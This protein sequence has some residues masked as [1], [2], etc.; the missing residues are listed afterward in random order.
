MKKY[1]RYVIEPIIKVINP[2][3][4]YF[5]EK[6]ISENDYLESGLFRNHEHF[7]G[8]D[9]ITGTIE[10]FEF[11]MSEVHT[12]Y[13]SGHG[14]NRTR[15]NIFD[16][17]FFVF[18]YKKYLQFYTCIHPDFAERLLGK[19]FGQKLQSLISS[20]KHG[21]LVKLENPDFEKIFKVTSTDQIES[22]TIL[23]PV[24]M[25]KMVRFYEE[26]GQKP[27]YFAFKKNI[28]YVGISK[29][30]NNRSIS[31]NQFFEPPSFLIMPQKASFNFA[32]NI[33]DTVN[34]P[35]EIAKEINDNASVW[36]K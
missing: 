27:I 14:K 28:V 1:K 10:D 5:P 9:L 8:D 36:K 26:V 7:K 4:K 31:P 12:Y 16:G 11:T 30:L 15:H 24:M 17:L 32:K 19:L 13:H 29:A 21:E 20:D 23:T 35:V 33:Y 22:R 18:K 6:H 25:E 34:I 3:F 2:S